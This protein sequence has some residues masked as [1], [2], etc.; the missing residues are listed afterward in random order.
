MGELKPMNMQGSIQTLFI[1][2]GGTLV[3][4][5]IVSA[6]ENRVAIMYLVKRG[7]QIKSLCK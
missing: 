2:C 3:L 7:L 4:S 1:L 6:V 5:G